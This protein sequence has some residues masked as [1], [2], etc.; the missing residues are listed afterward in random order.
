MSLNEICDG[1]AVIIEWFSSKTTF[2]E[3][4]VG[5]DA[6]LPTDMVHDALLQPQN[7][8]AP[9][10]TYTGVQGVYAPRPAAFEPL[11]STPVPVVPLGTY[12]R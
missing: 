6:Y 9:T 1:G 5:H 2:G 11:V 4:N 12:Y 7:A 3:I 8:Q 10:T